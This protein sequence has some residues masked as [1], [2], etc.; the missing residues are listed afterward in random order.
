M[1]SFGSWV[2][3]CLDEL[4]GIGPECVLHLGWRPYM[5]VTTAIN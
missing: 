3:N 2:S 4:V 1:A 5:E